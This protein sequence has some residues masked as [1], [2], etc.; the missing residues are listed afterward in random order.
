MVRGGGGYSNEP[1]VLVVE[2]SNLCDD[3]LTDSMTSLRERG[4]VVDGMGVPS[5]VRRVLSRL[6]RAARV[7]VVVV[8]LEA[9]LPATLGQECWGAAAGG[10]GGCGSPRGRTGAAGV[11]GS[12]LV[13]WRMLSWESLFISV[14]LRVSIASF[15]TSAGSF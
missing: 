15:S 7:V 12:R 1:Y 14:T 11:G 8:G 13:D 5:L 4:V 10:G 9:F 6:E 3:R 2:D